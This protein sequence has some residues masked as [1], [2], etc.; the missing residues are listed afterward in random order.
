MGFD[1]AWAQALNPLRGILA[2][3]LISM[4]EMMT[5]HINPEAPKL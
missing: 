4:D 3:A 5:I 1:T 2:A